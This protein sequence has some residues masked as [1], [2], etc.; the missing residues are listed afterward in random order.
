MQYVKI[1]ELLSSVYRI[2]R[3]KH[4]PLIEI[5]VYALDA[6]DTPSNTVQTMKKL[7][8]IYP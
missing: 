4:F 5:S 2:S 8:G 6:I 1:S 7:R 3:A